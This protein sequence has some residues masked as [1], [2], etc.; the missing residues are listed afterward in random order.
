MRIFIFTLL[1]N[2]LQLCAYAQHTPV[3]PLKQYLQDAIDNQLSTL[4]LADK[5]FCSTQ[6]HQPGQEGEF[7]RQITDTWL[8][9]QRK[10]LRDSRLQLGEVRFVPYDSLTAAEQPAKP[11]HMRDETSHT[12][13]ALYHGKIVCYFL[14][15]DARIASTLLLGMGEEHIFI[16]YCAT[17]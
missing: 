3:A 12:Y 4:A 7:A 16:N 5:Y 6:L 17:P 13:V 1:F 9:G 8:S 11:F 15:Q 10:N 14:L 2:S